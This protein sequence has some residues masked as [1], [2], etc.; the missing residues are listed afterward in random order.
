[1]VRMLLRPTP[2]HRAAG[3][4]IG[5][6][7]VEVRGKQ[8]TGRRQSVRNERCSEQSRGD[9]PFQYCAVAAFPSADFDKLVVVSSKTSAVEH[10]LQDER[11]AAGLGID[12]ERSSRER[13]DGC[14]I[15]SA[16]Q[17]EEPAVQTHKDEKIRAVIV[18][19]GGDDVIRAGMADL[20]AALF[21]SFANV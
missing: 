2:A 17:C 21:K 4:L 1:M 10:S 6:D 12:A 15:R 19:N 18:F 20:I 8:M 13:I 11:E 5:W 16:Y 7:H 3:A 9:L 14:A